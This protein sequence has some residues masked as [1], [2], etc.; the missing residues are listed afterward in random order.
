MIFNSHKSFSYTHEHLGW[1]EEKRVNHDSSLSWIYHKIKRV[2]WKW[3]NLMKILPCQPF[4]ND[5]NNF[6]WCTAA[7]AVHS[8]GQTDVGHVMSVI[9][10]R[11]PTLNYSLGPHPLSLAHSL[12]CTRKKKGWKC[13][14]KKKV[15]C[16]LLKKVN[17]RRDWKKMEKLFPST[18]EMTSEID[19][20][21][22][23]LLIDIQNWIKL[24]LYLSHCAIMSVGK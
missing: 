17:F 10:H 20:P 16:S 2:V 21:S 15:F 12:T 23:V 11:W 4:I 19:Y 6:L 8:D 7:A 18:A 22:E 9:W 5:N 24:Y 3:E 14:C 13:L 1:G